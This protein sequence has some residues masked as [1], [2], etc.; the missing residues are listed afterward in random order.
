MEK[1]C[2]GCKHFQ[3]ANPPMEKF[4]WCWAFDGGTDDRM[5]NSIHEC[6]ID[7]WEKKPNEQEE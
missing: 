5:L 3:V 1:H 6:H 2:S 7:K 4:G